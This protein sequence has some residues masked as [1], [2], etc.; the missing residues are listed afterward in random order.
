M[1]SPKISEE[2]IP[3]LYR[4]GKAMN[5]PMTK[6]VDEIMRTYFDSMDEDKDP[7][8]DESPF[9]RSLG[10]YRK[11]DKGEK[12][13]TEYGPA[14]VMKIEGYEQTVEKMERNGISRDEIDRFSSRVEHFLR[15]K[16]KYFEC[17][18]QYDDGEFEMIDW[19]QYLKMTNGKV[20]T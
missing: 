4:M 6:V 19:S 1:Y 15:D 8:W 20:E 11:P 13:Q 16:E 5:K 3:R 7:A 2:F 18:I 17:L 9:M 10:D 14:A 12:I